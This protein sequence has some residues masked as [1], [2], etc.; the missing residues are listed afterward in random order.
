MS[1]RCPYCGKDIEK[2]QEN[3]HFGNC[4]FSDHDKIEWSRFAGRGEQ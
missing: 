4:V 3:N 1:S 2:S